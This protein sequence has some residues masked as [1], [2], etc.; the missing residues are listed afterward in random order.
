MTGSPSRIKA[1]IWIVL[2][3]SLGLSSLYSIVSIWRRLLR[4][5]ALNEQTATINRPLAEEE[6]FDLIYQVLGIVSALVPVA[7]VLFL[8]ADTTR[9][10]FHR[11]GLDATRPGRDL[12]WS[13][14][15]AA[16]IGVPGLA[17]YAAGLALGLTVQVVPSALNATWWTIPI[18]LLQALKAGLVEEIIAVGYLFARLR[19][20]RIAPWV[21][22]I[23]QALLRATYHLYQGVG[24]FIGNFIMGVVFGWWYLRTQR[25]APLIGAHALIDAVA[26]VGYPV[27]VEAAPEFFGITP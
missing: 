3:L 5:E 18:L 12:L 14:G 2:G 15:L 13:V 27:A 7:L 6:F 1:E 4:E 23:L 20:L 11:L 9:P 25:L 22:V 10:R 24:P 16:V 19:D 26:F 21:I 17:L 8:L